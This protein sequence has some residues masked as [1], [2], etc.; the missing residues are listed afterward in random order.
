MLLEKSNIN[1]KWVLEKSA[2]WNIVTHYDHLSKSGVEK[3]YKV[4]F[5][6]IG[7]YKD[8]DI[9]LQTSIQPMQKKSGDINIQ[10]NSPFP[11]EET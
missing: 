9:K 8:S 1:I 6:T 11:I 5:K 7:D 4:C 2:S 10:N 3:L